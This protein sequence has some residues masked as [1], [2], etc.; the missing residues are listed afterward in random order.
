MGRAAIYLDHAA[1][2]P[3]HPDVLAA[4]LPYFSHEFGNPGGLYGLGQRAREAVEDAR[5][6]VAR[7]LGCA[8]S[9]IVFTSGGTESD[10][11]A[12]R[13]V[14]LAARARLNGQAP[15]IITSAIEHHAVDGT[16]HQLREHYG[17]ELTEIAVD[18]TG[19]VD[20]GDVMHA[21]RP[22]TVLISIMYANNEVGTIEPIADIGQMARERGIPFHTDA[23]QAAA[24]LP[25][26]VWT[27][28]VDLL[29]LGAHKFFGPKGVGA[30]Y[31]RRGTPL[32]PSQTGGG[33][34]GDRRAGT[35]NVPY[36][37]GLAAAL[38]RAQSHRAE[39]AAALDPLRRRLIDAIPATIA[40]AHLTGHPVERLPHNASFV[41]ERV[42]AGSVLAALD[43]AGV[44]ASS[45]SAC[46][47]ALQEPSHVLTAMGVPR[48][49]AAGA[50]RLTLGPENTL[51]EIDTVLETL[52][53]IVRRLRA[54][55]GG[56]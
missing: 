11:L 35:E 54:L 32:L 16:C 5:R 6:R 44:A 30:L 53:D 4:M 12:I 55:R 34:E 28:N 23:V 3:V 21:V 52:P 48:A 49:L 9:E 22:N 2:T 37:A 7:V 43:L 46:T 17:V 19:R 36:I 41:I 8:P 18:R 29:S 42:D 10:N 26:D 47:S 27:L 25:L 31:V 50:L 24:Y 13:G 1:T 15:H 51:A 33:H 40:D 38:E 56:A 45:G 14:V 39:H 20:P